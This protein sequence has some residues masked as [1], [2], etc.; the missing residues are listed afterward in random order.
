MTHSVHHPDRK[1]SALLAQIVAAVG[2][3]PSPMHT[4]LIAVDGPG[5]AGKSSFAEHLA[6]ALGGCQ[7]IH[8][9]DFASWEN[10]IDWGPELIEK[11]LD[12]LSHGQTGRF[13]PSRWKPEA[14]REH[15]EVV[16]AEFLVLEGV[17]SSR[18]AFRPYLVYAIWIEASHDVRLRRGLERDG[19]EARPQWERWIA[20][21]D[22]YR[23]RERP[24]ARADL[25][26]SGERDLW[27]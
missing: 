22:G 2:V 15:V 8:T 3:A 21:E 13:E 25:V 27:T 1:F 14:A 6:L 17:T 10:P 9:D 18:Q 12:P 16:P 7:I 11:V 20:E 4:R 23:Q 26:V 24:D 19:D 5:G